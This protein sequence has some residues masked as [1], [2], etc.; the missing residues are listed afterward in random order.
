MYRKYRFVKHVFEIMLS[1]G[2]LKFVFEFLF[3]EHRF[4]K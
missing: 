1:L 4:I 2:A 3:G